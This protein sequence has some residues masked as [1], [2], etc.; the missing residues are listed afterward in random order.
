M[1]LGR[2]EDRVALITGAARGQGEASHESSYVT[3][4]EFVVDGAMTCGKTVRMDQL[5]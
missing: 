1:T 4:A 2:L 5:A 3:G